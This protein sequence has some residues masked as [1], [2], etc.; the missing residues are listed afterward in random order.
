M[1]DEKMHDIHS[2]MD[3]IIQSYTSLS[4]MHQLAC[5]SKDEYNND[6]KIFL[7]ELWARWSDVWYLQMYSLALF[8]FWDAS[9]SIFCPSIDE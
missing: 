6:K 9:A 5:P 2:I 4:E 7:P 8:F 1:E 3:V